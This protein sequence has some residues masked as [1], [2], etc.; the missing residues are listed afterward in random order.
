MEGKPL[1]STV[2]KRLLLSN[3]AMTEWSWLHVTIYIYKKQQW[4]KRNWKNS[5][6]VTQNVRNRSMFP[7]VSLLIIM[8]IITIIVK[9]GLWISL[10]ILR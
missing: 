10:I 4:K 8:L 3:S 6:D 7:C 2:K 9:P 1:S 5:D